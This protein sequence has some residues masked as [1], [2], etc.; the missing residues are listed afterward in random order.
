MKFNN[1]TRENVSIKFN[2]NSVYY[3]LNAYTDVVYVEIN[4]GNEK[5]YILV[6]MEVKNNKILSQGKIRRIKE[7]RAIEIERKK[8]KEFS[9]SLLFL[10]N[11]TNLNNLQHFLFTLRNKIYVNHQVLRNRN[12]VNQ[13]NFLIL[14][15]V[16]IY[17]L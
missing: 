16:K 2:S 10:K 8:I 4:Y 12:F 5:I 17:L 9:N 6:H 3:L 1:L 14:N 11:C 13:Y 7:N 15:I